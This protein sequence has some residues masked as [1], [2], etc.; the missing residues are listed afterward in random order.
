[1]LKINHI[2]FFSYHYLTPVCI[3]A[4]MSKNFAFKSV[5]LFLTCKSYCTYSICNNARRIRF[6]THLAVI[7]RG[8]C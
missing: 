6:R 2:D 8:K 4:I 1:M 5:Q 7:K 3:R